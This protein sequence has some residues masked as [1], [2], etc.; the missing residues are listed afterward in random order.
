MQ[1]VLTAR[2]SVQLLPLY[3]PCGKR[4][5]QFSAAILLFNYAHYG[6][7]P[8]MNW[9]GTELENILVSHFHCDI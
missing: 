7:F 9:K 8:F 2:G 6:I 4:K 5:Q 1:E 3:F